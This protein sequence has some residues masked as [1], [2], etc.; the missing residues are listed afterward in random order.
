[1][2]T[3]Y[4]NCAAVLVRAVRSSSCAILLSSGVSSPW[5][6]GELLG[7]PQAVVKFL[8]HAARDCKILL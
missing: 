6:P 4:M 7:R 8:E 5:P 2:S 3:T 1:M